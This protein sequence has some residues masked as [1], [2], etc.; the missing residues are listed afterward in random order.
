MTNMEYWRQINAMQPGPDLDRLVAEQVMGI[1]CTC[2]Y[3][4]GEEPSWYWGSCHRHGQ[5]GNEVNYSTSEANA[6]KVLKVVEAKGNDVTIFTSNGRGV[7]V[8]VEDDSHGPQHS[9]KAPTFP[10]AMCKAALLDADW[11]RR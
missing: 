1:P 5:G 4:E 9:I 11:R 8:L 10:E 2:Q 7:R 6:W 3:E